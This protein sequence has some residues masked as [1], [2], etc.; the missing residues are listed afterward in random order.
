MALGC[1]HHPEELDEFSSVKR[2]SAAVSQ[3]N[4]RVNNCNLPVALSGERWSANRPSVPR[5]QVCE[6]DGLDS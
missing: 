6:F 4:R 2:I 1:G 5:K 3:F